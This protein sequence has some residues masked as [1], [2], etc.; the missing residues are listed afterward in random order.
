VGVGDG[1][2][3]LLVLRWEPTRPAEAPPLVFVAGWVSAVEGWLDLLRVLTRNRVVY[4]VETREKRSAEVPGR[5]LT[6]KDFSIE[7]L[8]ADIVGAADA[9]DV[10]DGSATFMGSSMGATSIIE[11]M[12]AGGLRARSAFL[13][14]PNTEFRFPLWSHAVMHMP[15]VSWHVLKHI[16][17]WYLRTFRVDAKK[18]PEQMA[19]YDRTLRSAHP[20]RI[21]LSGMAVRGFEIWRGLETITTPV[22]VAYSPTDTLH[23]ESNIERLVATLPRGHAVQCPTNRYMHSADIA[24]DLASFEAQLDSTDFFIRGS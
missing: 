13:V 3:R 5:R 10:N 18:E 14:G 23:D 1:P 15:A 12:K 6:P 11:A 21:K 16:A 7:R 20:Q 22:A 4:Y 24:E 19:R 9:L 2:A 17:L 8:A